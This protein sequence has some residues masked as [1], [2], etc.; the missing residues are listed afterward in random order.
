MHTLEKGDIIEIGTDASP[1]GMEG[2]ATVNGQI[3]YFFACPI[4][5]QD[6]DML[7][8]STGTS[9]GQQVCGR[10]AVLVAVDLW[11]SMWKQDRIQLKVR[12]D[13]VTALTLLIK[14]RPDKDSPAMGIIAREL[15][16]RLVEL[17]FPPE[18]VHT[19]GVAHVIADS[20]S[21]I[22]APG[23][24]GV[25]SKDAHPALQQAEL[26]ALPTRDSAWYRA[27]K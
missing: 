6:V 7:G 18:A 16:L 22:H 24:S 19:P 25:V 23:G 26:S 17:S 4:D 27:Y 15:A 14:M 8:T 13:N 3:K 21:R 20:L 1:W 12:G 2:W 11:S 9:S 5:A 10:L